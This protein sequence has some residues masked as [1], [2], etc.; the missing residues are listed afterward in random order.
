MTATSTSITLEK[1]LPQPA[2]DP[3]WSPEQAKEIAEAFDPRNLPAS[4]YDDPFPT[5][6]A[7]LAHDP[8]HRCPDGSW[9]LTRYADLD[10]IYRDTASFSSDKKIEF[11]PK[12]GDSPLYEH[13][14]TSLVFSD[15]PLHTR[16]RKIMVGALNPRAL[17]AMEPGLI[18]L[19]DR[20]I[21]ALD[22]KDEAELIVGHWSPVFEFDGRL[23]GRP[24]KVP[25]EFLVEL[26]APCCASGDIDRP[27]S[28]RGH[29]P[30]GRIRRDPRLRP[31]VGRDRE[32]ILNRVLG[33]RDVAE[34]TDQGRHRLAVDLPEDRSDLGRGVGGVAGR[35]SGVRCGGHV[36]LRAPCR[37][38]RPHLDRVVG[39]VR[40]LVGPGTSGVKDGGGCVGP[41]FCLGTPISTAPVEG[42]HTGPGQNPA[43]AR[44]EAPHVASMQGVHIDLL[45]V[46]LEGR[47]GHALAPQ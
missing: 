26:A 19:V 4:F 11:W 9:F 34:D 44:L 45:G 21:A 6:R 35:H 22:G 38:E 20:L 2:P 13:H 41:G 43:A 17:A 27:V 29:D 36:V 42:Q 12:Y 1:W 25:G 10:R 15:P 7:L 3:A 16:V 5:Y 14:T 18:A 31:L 32:G 23:G 47:G 46:R 37:S 33:K 40:D 24:L 8:V 39:G 30:A 28:S